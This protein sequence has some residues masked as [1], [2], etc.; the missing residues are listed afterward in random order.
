MNAHYI[1][2]VSA[3][4]GW[5]GV[6]GFSHEHLSGRM[7]RFTRWAEMTDRQW[8]YCYMMVQFAAAIVVYIPYHAFKG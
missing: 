5:I 8:L 7:N 3:I 6:I 1:F 4:I 2:V